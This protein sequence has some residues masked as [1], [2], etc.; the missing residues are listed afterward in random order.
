[1]GHLFTIV[2]AWGGQLRWQVRQPL[3]LLFMTGRGPATLP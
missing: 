1:M 2:M 3:Q